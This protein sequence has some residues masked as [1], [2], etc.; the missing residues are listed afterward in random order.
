M[1]G[2]DDDAQDLH[3]GMEVTVTPDDRGGDPDV[4][5]QIRHLDHDI[6][7][8]LRR[9]PVAGEVAVHFPRVG[10]RIRPVTAKS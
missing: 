4:R 6:V 5:G 9:D 3:P 8:L 1:C 2:I 7:S 10:Y